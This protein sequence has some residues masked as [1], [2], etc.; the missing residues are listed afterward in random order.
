MKPMGFIF[1]VCALFTLSLSAQ[2]KP[3]S[4]KIGFNSYQH[5]LND[6]LKLGFPHEED[7]LQLSFLKNKFPCPNQNLAQIN[8]SGQIV[9][10]EHFR[11]P[12]LKPDF[13][14]NMPVMKP[15]STIHYHLLIKKI[16]K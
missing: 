7:N 12:V 8:E 6:T 2:T 16:G 1:V 4:I 11:M 15:D 10:G 14:S 5:I 9:N 13:R 3:D